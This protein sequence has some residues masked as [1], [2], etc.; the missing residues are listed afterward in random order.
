MDKV[1]LE[2]QHVAV[3]QSLRCDIERARL[4]RDVL[5]ETHR[6][7]TATARVEREATRKQ[8]AELDADL[9]RARELSIKGTFD[10]DDF[11]AEK[12][13]I[14][15]NQFELKDRLA[16]LPDDQVD[17]DRVS[18]FAFGFLR[19]IDA[20][21][22]YGDYTMQIKIDRALSPEGGVVSKK[23]IQTL[24]SPFFIGSLVSPN[25]QKKSMVAR[26]GF[27]PL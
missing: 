19:D 23:K 13:R 1:D 8:L 27:E 2:K 14:E 12:G 17:V 21:W 15:K 3:L 20:R 25:G 7:L 5:V 6:E 16:K 26:K 4:F 10:A 9:S 18:A 22:A 11:L 24:K